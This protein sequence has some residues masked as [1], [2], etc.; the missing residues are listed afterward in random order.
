MGRNPCLWKFSNWQALDPEQYIAVCSRWIVTFTYF[1]WLCDSVLCSSCRCGH[2]ARRLHL[3][4][5]IFIK[6]LGL[7]AGLATK[8]GESSAKWKRDHLLKFIEKLLWSSWWQ[9]QNI[10]PSTES[11]LVWAHMTLPVV[12]PM[13]PTL[14]GRFCC[15][16][17]G[18]CSSLL[19]NF[20]LGH[21]WQL[22]PHTC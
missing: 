18:L 19:L 16:S 8:F 9:W 3:L 2:P 15:F 1:Q 11:F 10:K 5:C 14:P 7:D 21:W 22:I 13:K 17:T 6:G 12:C 4:P 20:F